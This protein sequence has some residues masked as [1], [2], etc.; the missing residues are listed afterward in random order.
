MKES[1]LWIR[2]SSIGN[3]SDHSKRKSLILPGIYIRPGGYAKKDRKG[4]ETL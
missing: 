3:A 2:K 1:P 4:D